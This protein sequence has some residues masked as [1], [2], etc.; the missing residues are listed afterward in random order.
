MNYQ[1]ASGHNEVVNQEYYIGSE[2]V[3]SSFQLNAPYTKILNNTRSLL[4]RKRYEE[5]FTRLSKL[6]LKPM[7]KATHQYYAYIL[8]MYEKYL[9]MALSLSARKKKIEAEEYFIKALAYELAFQT[10]DFDYDIERLNNNITFYDMKRIY[11]EGKPI[12][13]SKK[14]LLDIIYLIS[15]QSLYDYLREEN[16]YIADFPLKHNIITLISLLVRCQ[17]YYDECNPY[18]DELKDLIGRY[19]KSNKIDNDTVENIL[20]LAG[21][22][23][24]KINPDKLNLDNFYEL[25]MKGFEDDDKIGR[26][27]NHSALKRKDF[28]AKGEESDLQWNQ[29]VL[30]LKRHPDEDPVTFSLNHAD[31]YRAYYDFGAKIDQPILKEN[32]IFL[33]GKAGRFLVIGIKDPF[34]CTAISEQEAKARIRK[35]GYLDSL[36]AMFEKK[37]DLTSEMINFGFID[38]NKTVQIS[39]MEKMIER[40][41]TKDLTSIALMIIPEKRAS[42]FLKSKD[43]IAENSSNNVKGKITEVSEE[44]IFLPEEKIK[45]IKDKFSPSNIKIAQEISNEGIRAK[46]AEQ[47]DDAIRYYQEV[48]RMFP[49]AGG[50]YYNL[51][52]LFYIIGDFSRAQKAYT[53]AYINN[54]NVFDETLFVHLGHALLDPDK[55]NHIVHEYRKDILGHHGERSAKYDTQCYIYGKEHIESLKQL[56][57][58]ELIQL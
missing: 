8:F 33:N 24:A 42:D 37:P 44:K 16:E 45:K 56:Y 6:D 30:W 12:W 21:R 13:S 11:K 15:A 41:G 4:R 20:E 28:N 10:C 17:P 29:S 52:K 7:L 36:N 32:E 47:F 19:G 35:N 49:T 50:I 18:Y 38:P 14:S 51:G 9:H 1:F 48:I 54:A 31:Y 2:N 27:Q 34:W 46:R 26:I 39:G 58:R 40:I 23:L 5:C 43:L 57:E 53:L 3:F 55:D 25:F 22:H